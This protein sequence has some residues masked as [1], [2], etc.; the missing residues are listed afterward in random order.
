M[1]IAS[2][3]SLSF[4]LQKI[5]DEDSFTINSTDRVGLVGRNG[6]GKSTLFKIISGEIKPDE[7]CISIE[8][9]KTIAYIP[10]E[11]TLNSEKT[12]FD[13][14][15]S[16]FEKLMHLKQEQQLL[17]NHL[18]ND[19]E[20]IEKYALISNQLKEFDEAQAKVE[21]E[22]ILKGL[23]FT[24]RAILESV[25]N[26][27]LGWKMRIV[28]AKLLL[29]KADFYLFDEP[30]NH[31]DL[32]TKDWFLNF[33]KNQK[34][35]FLLVCHDKYFLDKLCTSIFEL[36][37]GKMTIYKGNYN[38]YVQ[39]KERRQAVLESEY[40]AQQKDIKQKMAVVERFRAKASKAK[41][42]QSMLK[43]IEKIEKITI[44]SAPKSVN[45][46]FSNIQRSGN[47]VLKVKNL[48]FAFDKNYIF[49]NAS[50]EILR[51]EKVGIVA[52][53]GTGKTT[54]FNVITGKYKQT[55]GDIIMGH[56]VSMAVFEQDQNLI[57]DHKKTILDEIESSCRAEERPNVRKFL[58]AFLF[59][60]DD[61]KK[62]ISFLSGGEKNRV[63]MVK[64]LLQKS[65]FL[66]LD[67]PTNHLDIQ[68]KDILLRALK[69]FEGTILFVSHDQ[70][71]LNRLATKILELTPK[72]IHSYQG[73]YEDFLLQKNNA[74]VPSPL[75]S[76]QNSNQTPTTEIKT[77]D[78]KIQYEIRKKIKSLENKIE[79]LEAEKDILAKKI[80]LLT[81]GTDEFDKIYKQQLA[82][83]TALHKLFTEWESLCAESQAKNQSK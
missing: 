16:T 46:K 61:V 28:L 78:N 80:S 22:K 57:L 44:H 68:S 63:A 23:G 9:G 51:G 41:M 45:F 13:E 60:G 4:G 21:T 42:A 71:F 1:I 33:L 59:S 37:L 48:S 67:E 32:S 35:G 40:A 39:E 17:E 29:K 27:S 54:L 24:P 25:Q 65:N 64:V 74:I 3:I 10:Q 73:N 5:F 66:I 31:L 43:S 50:F 30:T 38:F 53:N 6:S 82:N 12:V 70:D 7:G 62:K 58:G 56:N 34:F 76:K 47:S 8:K 20:K 11:I 14:T 81:F 15:F 83:D 36:E 2:K 69:E 79:R 55:S 77:N 49:Q 52:P 26:L 19:H 18:E 75:E 72:G